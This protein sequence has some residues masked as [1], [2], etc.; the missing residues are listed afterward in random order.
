MQ[1]VCHCGCDKFRFK[2]EESDEGTPYINNTCRNCTHTLKEH[3][4]VSGK[5]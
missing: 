2:V 4:E 1:R 5:E 3:L